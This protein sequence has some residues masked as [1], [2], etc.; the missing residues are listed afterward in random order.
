M[1][2]LSIIIPVYNEAKTVHLLLNKVKNVVLS[3][4]ISKEVIIVNDCSTDGTKEV[5]EI[6][7]R[8]NPELNIQFFNHE[9][10]KGKGAALHTGIANATGDYTTSAKPSRTGC[11]RILYSSGLYSKSAS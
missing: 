11:S 7:S 5:I 10:N 3:N 9:I 4:G 1:R 6:Y 8:E 2:K